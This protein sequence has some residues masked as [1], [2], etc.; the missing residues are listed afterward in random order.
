M[1]LWSGISE[2]HSGHHS[3]IW[4]LEG[5]RIAILVFASISSI[6][7]LHHFSISWREIFAHLLSDHPRGSRSE[8]GRIDTLDSKV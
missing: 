8:R 4:I 3:A 7:I 5:R 2:H 6:F 1:A